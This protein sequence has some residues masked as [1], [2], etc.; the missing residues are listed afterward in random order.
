MIKINNYCNTLSISEAQRFV[1]YITVSSAYILIEQ[2]SKH[3]GRSLMYKTKSRG[4]KIEPWDAKTDC[5]C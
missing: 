5:P 1:K 2:F 3:W 4:P